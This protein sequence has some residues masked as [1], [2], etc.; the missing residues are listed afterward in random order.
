M[1]GH[2][3]LIEMRKT[4]FVPDMVFLD[5]DV[6]AME[7]WRD[8]PANNNRNCHILIE[9]TDKRFDFRCF[10]GLRCYVSG[11]TDAKRVQA[12]RDALIDAGAS[13][14]IATTFEQVGRDEFIA[15]RVVD[16]T[17]TAALEAIDG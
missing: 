9:P 14:V 17:D 5:V 6:D 8:W 3:P 15:Y 13:R 1:R 12:I 11:H 10:A 16:T 4:G 2:E 7:S